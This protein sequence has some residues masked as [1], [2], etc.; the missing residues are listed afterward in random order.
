MAKASKKSKAKKQLRS[1]KYD[2][3]LA[4]NGTFL[5]VMKAAAKH[6]ELKSESKKESVK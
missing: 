1:K 6:A 3:K 5:D 4:I 2:E